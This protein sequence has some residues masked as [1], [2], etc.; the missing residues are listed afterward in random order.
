MVVFTRTHAHIRTPYISLSLSAIG[1]QVKNS[2]A[3]SPRTPLWLVYMVVLQVTL[4]ASTLFW[5]LLYSQYNG[6]E[7][8]EVE[9]IT[10][11]Q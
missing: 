5:L 9:L 3:E 4:V 7:G 6:G 11:G 8:L 1:E 2:S 10:N